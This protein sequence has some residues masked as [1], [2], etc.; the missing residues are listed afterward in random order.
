MDTWEYHVEAG[1]TDWNVI[2]QMLTQ[3]GS[4]GWELVSFGLADD[5]KS[6][7][8]ENTTLLG[9]MFFAVLKRPSSS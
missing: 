8:F 4:E 1:Q 3:V 5:V 7:M 6:G 9:G 2:Q